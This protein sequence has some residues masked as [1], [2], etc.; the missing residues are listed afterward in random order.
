MILDRSLLVAA[1]LLLAGCSGETTPASPSS[2]QASSSGSG[3]GSWMGSVS[4]PV[5]GAGTATL[6]LGEQPAGPSG[7]AT[8]GALAG[9][10]AFTFRNGDTIAGPAEGYLDSRNSFGLILTVDPRQSCQTTPGS[11]ALVH[12]QLT[13]A[14]VTSSRF[15]A[16]LMRMSCTGPTFGTV[17]LVRQ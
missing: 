6:V 3:A 4:D 8:Q 12:Y 11:P 14:V 5:V 7:T 1:L 16:V 10:W 2:S 17:S 13:N 15:T 9:T